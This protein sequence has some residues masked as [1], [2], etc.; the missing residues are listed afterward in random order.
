MDRREFLGTAAAL[1]V[2]ALVPTAEAKALPPVTNGGSLDTDGWYFN[3][4][5]EVRRYFD[6]DDPQTRYLVGGDYSWRVAYK[7][8]TIA[9]ETHI[10]DADYATRVYELLTDGLL[11]AAR[12]PAG[13]CFWVYYGQRNE[14]TM[15]D[16]DAM[17][18]LARF[19]MR[20]RAPRHARFS[21]AETRLLRAGDVLANIL[22]R[23]DNP[24][25]HKRYLDS[26]ET[27]R[28]FNV[29]YAR[30]QQNEATHRRN[31]TV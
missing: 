1:G 13:V 22:L 29:V 14:N 17:V 24:A 31:E 15:P 21:A 30:Q 28:R 2:A 12:V 7:G 19:V 27:S 25:Q 11:A 9:D 18:A 5:Q 3:Y 26:I 23:L 4:S 16:W 8:R 10:R 20:H 6:A